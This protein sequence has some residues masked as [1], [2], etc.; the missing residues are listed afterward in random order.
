LKTRVNDE[1]TGKILPKKM[2]SHA[3]SGDLLG[4]RR[5]ESVLY[6][7]STDQSVYHDKTRKTTVEEKIASEGKF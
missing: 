5:R 1:I 2:V 6:A 3:E 7:E 4:M